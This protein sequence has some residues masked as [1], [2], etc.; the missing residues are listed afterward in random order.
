MVIILTEYRS[1]KME[2][3]MFQTIRKINIIWLRNVRTSSFGR[4]AGRNITNSN[5]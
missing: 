3:I 5:S 1:I 2:N 4:P